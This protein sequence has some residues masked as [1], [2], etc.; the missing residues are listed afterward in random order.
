[1]DAATTRDVAKK[2]LREQRQPQ[3]R[4]EI[5]IYNYYKAMN[6]VKANVKEELTVELVNEIHRIHVVAESTEVVYT[7]PEAGEIDSWIKSL[8]QFANSFDDYFIHPV[9]K[10]IILRFTGVRRAA[11]AKQPS[12]L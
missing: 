2:M 3:H 12:C 7:P 11:V 4:S 1:V 10:A 6:F 9:I 5:M 8:C